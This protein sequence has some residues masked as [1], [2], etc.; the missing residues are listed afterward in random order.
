M[1]TDPFPAVPRRKLFQEAYLPSPFSFA[2]RRSTLHGPE[3]TVSIEEQ[4][5]IKTPAPLAAVWEDAG[6]RG[7]YLAVLEE[8]Q[9]QCHRFLFTGEVP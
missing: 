3:G 6:F 9:K 2:V 8:H 4:E 7:E 1:H 5:G